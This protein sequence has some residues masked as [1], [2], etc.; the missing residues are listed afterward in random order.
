[1]NV[2]TTDHALASHPSWFDPEPHPFLYLVSSAFALALL[3]TPLILWRLYC[4][5]T[6]DIGAEP[7]PFPNPWLCLAWGTAFAI[8]L[9]M[10]CAMPAVLLFLLLAR[11]LHKR[12]AAQISRRA[13]RPTVV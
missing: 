1:M 12:Q 10:L 6:S 7:N 11:S 13:S 2:F 5:A 8:V 9:S 4:C 3:L